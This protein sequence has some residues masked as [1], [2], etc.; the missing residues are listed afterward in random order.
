MIQ[1]HFSEEKMKSILAVMPEYMEVYKVVV[2]GNHIEYRTRDLFGHLMLPDVVSRFFKEMLDKARE[3]DKINHYLSYPRR[4]VLESGFNS[5]NGIGF[6][7]VIKLH[8]AFEY[9]SNF[10]KDTGIRSYYNTF[11]DKNFLHADAGIEVNFEF[12][13]LKCAIKRNWILGIGKEPDG[14]LVVRSKYLIVPN[15][16]S[17]DIRGQYPEDTHLPVIADPF[18]AKDDFSMPVE[19]FCEP[20]NLATLEEHAESMKLILT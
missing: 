13:L 7:S 1:E 14:A 16:P 4:E 3:R 12:R 15:Y 20:A 19:V 2:I 11:F 9:Y 18:E 8:T 5:A 17:V 10:V 6:H